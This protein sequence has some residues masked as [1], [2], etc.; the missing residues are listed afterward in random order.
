ME[1][2]MTGCFGKKLQGRSVNG[3][4]VLEKTPCK[5]KQDNKT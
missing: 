4:G 2:W 1:K 3:H 5:T